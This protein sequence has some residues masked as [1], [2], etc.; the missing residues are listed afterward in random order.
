MPSTIFT[1]SHIVRSMG[2]LM[3]VLTMM[4]VGITGWQP[5]QHAQAQVDLWSVEERLTGA[6]VD[7][8]GPDIVIDSQGVSHIVYTETDF[9]D[10]G[11]VYYINNRAGTWGSPIPISIDTRTEP[12]GGQKA[13]SIAS[14]TNSGIVHLGIAY[15]ARRG[16]GSRRILF[17]ESGDGGQ[18]WGPIETATTHTSLHPSFVYDDTFQPHLV[19]TKGGGGDLSVHYATRINGTWV[20]EGIGNDVDRNPDIVYTRD[21]TN[22][23]WLHVF[24]QTAKGFNSGQQNMRIVSRYRSP[25]GA[26]SSTA[27]RDSDIAQYPKIAT[28]HGQFV[29]AVWSAKEGGVDIDPFFSASSDNGRSWGSPLVVGTRS[30]DLGQRPAI[31]RSPATGVLAVI[32][33]DDYEASE[34][35]YDIYGRMSTD[36]GASWSELQ[37]V[38][39]ASGGSGSSNISANPTG[40]FR[41]VWD[42]GNSGRLRVFTSGFNDT[43]GSGPLPTATPTQVAAPIA[44]LDVVGIASNRDVVK[45]TSAQVNFS[46]LSGV[47]DQYQLSNDGVTFTPQLYG[48][49]VAGQPVNWTLPDGPPITCYQFT[50]YGRVRSS[51]NPESVSEIVFDTFQVDPGVDATVEL[52]SDW[53]G[54]P[55]YTSADIPSVRVTANAGECSRLEKFQVAP[56]EEQDGPQNV[57]VSVTDGAGHTQEYNLAVTRDTVAPSVAARNDSMTAQPADGG[58]SVN[59]SLVDLRFNNVYI[60]D[61]YVT[62][63]G[64]P[65]GV[66]LANSRSNILVTDTVGLDR[67]EWEPVPVDTVQKTSS[68]FRFNV[69]NWNMIAGLDNTEPGTVYIYA[70]IIDGAGNMSLETLKTSIRIDGEIIISSVYLPIIRR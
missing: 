28:D 59:S 63:N 45:G 11:I 31:A 48:P 19:Y 39:R 20:A 51:Q 2:F 47:A 46:V 50:V 27:E 9:G 70:H 22:A 61:T 16:D 25:S 23:L 32:W 44:A 66:L 53:G 24:Y 49:L 64:K 5:Y 40:G 33:E 54:D 17:R 3:L 30:S 67:L 65:W 34:F 12:G 38:F 68:G 36:G 43:G 10:N 35:K 6:G 58:Q 37:T 4:F 41:A 15:Q 7:S 62:D 14:Y 42:D 69:D 56:L 60:T 21:T 1:R 57:L 18:T 26:W 55:N 13:V 29:A 8:V 52:T